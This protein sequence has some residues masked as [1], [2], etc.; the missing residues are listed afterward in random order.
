V[1][2]KLIVFEGVEGCGKT[3]QI[4]QTSEWLHNLGFSVI[5]TREPGGTE[6]GLQLRR[7]LLETSND[8]P[9]VSKTELLLYAADRSQHVE[10]ELLPNLASGKFILCDR[11]TD[12]TVAYQGY[13]RALDMDLIQQLNE[14]ATG[15]LNS[16][17]T[18]WLDIEV[19]VG[20]S[21]KKRD[22]LGLDRMEQEKIEFHRRVRQGYT[23]LH[24]SNPQRIV[25][26][27][28]SLSKEAVQE[29]IQQILTDKL[30][31]WA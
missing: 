10:Q 1:K 20:F 11:Y 30:K 2:G 15:G 6:L 17:L 12:S 24:T 28:G 27:D 16:D 5:A 18:I 29:E 21:R 13:G 22:G 19:E 9:I 14:I 26:I 23:E 31:N 8:K 7:L 4:Q 3:T 25:K